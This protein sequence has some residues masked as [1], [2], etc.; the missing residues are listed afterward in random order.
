MKNTHAGKDRFPTG[1]NQISK[2]IFELQFQYDS[3]EK[4]E[5]IDYDGNCLK[6][7]NNG[8]TE[9]YKNLKNDIT[10]SEILYIFVDG[11]LF[12]DEI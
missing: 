9:Q 12:D 7:K 1:T 3:I 11:V 5:W 8:S 2:Y 10:H 6:L 4:F